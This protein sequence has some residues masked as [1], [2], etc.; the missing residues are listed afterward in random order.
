MEKE[1]IEKQLDEVI[2]KIKE[3]RKARIKISDDSFVDVILGLSMNM[4]CVEDVPK[5]AQAL[6]ETFKKIDVSEDVSRSFTTRYEMMYKGWHIFSYDGYKFGG[7]LYE[8]N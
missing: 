8:N 7:S 3:L 6:G 2:E 1:D 4:F 5:L